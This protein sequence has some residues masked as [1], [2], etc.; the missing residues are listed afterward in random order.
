MLMVLSSAGTIAGLPT[1]M[2]FLGYQIF[3]MIKGGKLRLWGIACFIGVIL[4]A[5]WLNLGELQ[6]W[7]RILSFI[8]VI[9][10]LVVFVWDIQRRGREIGRD[11]RGR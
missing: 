9:V 1:V 8:C 11:V 10:A 4:S 2:L 5:I 3:F 7:T 6:A